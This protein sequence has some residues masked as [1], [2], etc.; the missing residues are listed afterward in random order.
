M[1][2]S[3]ASSTVAFGDHLWEAAVPQ[4]GSRRADLPNTTPAGQKQS[5]VHKFCMRLGGQFDLSLSSMYCLKYLSYH[6]RV[7][8]EG[9]E[10][11]VV[12]NVMHLPG[13]MCLLDRQGTHVLI[14]N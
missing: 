4:Q 12:M 8:L 5:L 2:D 7:C 6:I 11:Y 13:K 14:F 1:D 3:C 9:V 10:Y